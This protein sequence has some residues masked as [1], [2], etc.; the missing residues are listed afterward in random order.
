MRRLV[1]N[2]LSAILAAIEIYN[3]PQMTYRDEVTVTLVVN[4]WELALKA[5]LRQKQKSIFYRK[6]RNE[7]YRSFA[8]DDCLGRVTAQNL[9]PDHID[10]PGV[11]A[12]IKALTEYRNRAI[13]LY[14]AQGLSAVIYPFLQQNIINYRDFML[15]RFKKD[16]ADSITWQLLPLGAKAPAD[17]VKFLKTDSS[18]TTVSE[19]QEFIETLRGYM[20]EAEASGSEMDRVATVYDVNMQSIKKM[21]SADLV[22]AIS[23]TGDGQVVIKK[24]DPNQTHPYSMKKL[25]EKVN[26]RRKGRKLTTYDFQAIVWQG[27]LRDNKRYAWK[28]SNAASHVWSGDAL[29]HLSSLEDATY[30]KARTAYGKHQKSKRKA[31]Q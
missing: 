30:D 1:N 26:G 18:T 3:K 20:D 14:N 10:G 9:W 17:A 6:R 27:D 16:L 24:S 4:A 7:P 22:V 19:V 31:A 13:H 29:T 5:A 2:S 25:L 21:T 8:L 28:H 11:V 23:Q 15:E 12:N